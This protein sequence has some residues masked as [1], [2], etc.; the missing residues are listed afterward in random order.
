MSWLRAYAYPS[1]RARAAGVARHTAP[2]KR[3]KVQDCNAMPSCVYREAAA[4][5]SWRTIKCVSRQAM[6]AIRVSA[7][8]A[9]RLW[10]GGV[11]SYGNNPIHISSH[12]YTRTHQLKNI[13]KNLKKKIIHVLSIVLHIGLKS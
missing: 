3:T 12:V 7:S 8:P 2:R 9:A 11:P 5:G 1:R 4:V 6:R 10:L 13:T